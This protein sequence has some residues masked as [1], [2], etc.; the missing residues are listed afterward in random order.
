M[1]LYMWEGPKALAGIWHGG[2][3]KLEWVRPASLP[4]S[5]PASQAISLLV[6]Q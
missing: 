6:S 3:W 4:V 1:S 2:K 5:Q